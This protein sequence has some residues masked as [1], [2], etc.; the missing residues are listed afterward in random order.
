MFS[1]YLQ[2]H[3]FNFQN[4]KLFCTTLVLTDH[5]SYHDVP[6]DIQIKKKI[7]SDMKFVYKNG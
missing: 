7:S 5:L 6:S 3:S 2:R 4:I 1:P